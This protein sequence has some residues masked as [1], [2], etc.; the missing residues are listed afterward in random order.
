MEHE[1]RFWSLDFPNPKIGLPPVVVEQGIVVRV[2]IAGHD[3]TE[4]AVV[5]GLEECSDTTVAKRHK[6]RLG[7]LT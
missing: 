5:S 6:L 1:E 3:F 7:L 4:R 2:E